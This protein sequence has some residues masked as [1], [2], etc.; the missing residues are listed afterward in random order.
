M[1]RTWNQENDDTLWAST[2]TYLKKLTEK[3][4][5]FGLELFVTPVCNQKCEYCY[6]VNNADKLYPRD[7]RNEELIL[8]NLD[9]L[10]DFLIENDTVPR[11]LDLFSGEI[12]D[13]PFGAKV[14]KK[15]LRLVQCNTSTKVEHL[16]IPT[17]FSFITNDAA[18]A[19]IEKYIDAFKFYGATFSLSC[20]YDGPMIENV[21]R[22]FNNQK[23]R[24]DKGTQEYA[25]LLFDWCK[26]QSF[27]F[28]P[29]VNAYS[30]EQWPQQIKWWIDQLVKYDLNLYNYTMF[31]EV[32]N[33]EWTDD[34]IA[35]YL[36]YLN[37][38]I[39][40]S[41]EKVH[42]NDIENFMRHVC[43]LHLGECNEQHKAKNYNAMGFTV[44]CKSKGCS[45]D[46]MMCVRLGDLAWAPCHRVSYEKLLYGR[47]KVNENNKITGIQALNI[48]MFV[49]INSLTYKGHIKCDICP[50]RQICMRGCYGAQ[51]EDSKEI[52]YPC[53]TVCE[54]FMAKWLF[55]KEKYKQLYFTN[56]T[57][58]PSDAVTQHY[59]QMCTMI[60]NIDKEKQNKWT[61]II[62][63]TLSES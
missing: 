18:R 63:K 10:I 60:N 42:H 51:L 48:P 24:I 45:V 35:A 59:N 17:N 28:H 13:T 34:K 43:N 36:K 2:Q 8:K 1:T 31:L 53:D 58:T 54:L 14:L 37:T 61:P 29:M 30:I 55:L 4:T 26:K 20:S 41:L 19:M 11:Q 39:D 25:D 21:N 5:G 6:L 40:Y 62:L 22:P 23:G 16:T 47:F 38:F 27:G 15:L 50:I 46:R 49:A 44:G 9:I 57:I 52:F 33:N 56:P 7:I 3:D 12:W 32:R